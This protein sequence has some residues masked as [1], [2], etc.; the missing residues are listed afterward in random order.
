MIKIMAK[1]VGNKIIKKSLTKSKTGI[2][3]IKLTNC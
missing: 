2:K 1:S 3:F